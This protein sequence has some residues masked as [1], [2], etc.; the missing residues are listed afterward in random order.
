MR[1]F[2]NQIESRRSIRKFQQEPIAPELLRELVRLAALS[3]S[4][5]NLQPL[6]FCIL[7][8]PDLCEKFFNYTHWA[9]YLTNG[10]PR[11]GERP[12][13][14]L[15]VLGDNEIRKHCELDAGIALGTIGLAAESMGLATCLIGAL[16]REQIY[17]LLG[18]P[19]RYEIHVAVAI[20]RAAMQAET[21]EMHGGDVRY[22]YEGERFFVPKRPLSEV[23]LLEK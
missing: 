1:D 18:L 13:A 2:L 8:K 20:G 22:F 23:L 21:C 16:D 10:A 19:K 4:G 6:K 15:L 14:Y 3:P 11:E 7:S 5:A 12:T 17:H 9:G